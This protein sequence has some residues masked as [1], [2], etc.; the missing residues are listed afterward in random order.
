MADAAPQGPP[1]TEEESQLSAAKK[2]CGA[3]TKRRDRLLGCNLF[4]LWFPSPHVS[5]ALLHAHA[6]RTREEYKRW[7]HDRVVKEAAARKTEE[8]QRLAERLKALELGLER[9]QHL[10]RP[11]GVSVG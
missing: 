5:L 11:S 8:E 10:V 9:Q 4:G 7:A 2:W 1:M 6:N 3:E